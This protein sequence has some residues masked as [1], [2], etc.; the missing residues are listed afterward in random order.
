MTA[1]SF[2]GK[3]QQI[4]KWSPRSRRLMKAEVLQWQAALATVKAKSTRIVP[5][6]PQASKA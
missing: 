2:A 4:R 6:P 3:L 5:Q 1:D